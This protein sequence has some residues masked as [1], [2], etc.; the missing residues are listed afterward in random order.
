[1]ITV[2][3][4]FWVVIGLFAGSIIAAAVWGS[5]IYYRLIYLWGLLLI[6]SW[7]WTQLS[8]RGVRVSR[9]ARTTRQQV[10]QVFE[11]R[12]EL[13]NDSRLLRLWIEIRDESTLPGSAGSRVLTWIGGRQSR[14]YL[15]YSWLTRRGLFTLGPTMITS[16]DLFG[17]FSISQTIPSH[18]A[19]LVT[20][21]LVELQSFPSPA[22]LLPGGRSLQRRT[23]EVTPYA[24]G[25]REYSPGTDRTAST[26][27]P[28]PGETSS[29]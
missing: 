11:E 20:P 1:M 10:G 19:L 4:T 2:H 18:H 9:H 12:F 15:S 17:L 22:G 13:D 28:L 27:R 23:L 3:R 16:G 24:A 7:A 8:L 21:F 29:W 5:P 6:S 25:V 26:G 14:S